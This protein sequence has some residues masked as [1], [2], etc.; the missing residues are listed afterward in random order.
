MVKSEKDL[1]VGCLSRVPTGQDCCQRYKQGIISRADKWELA[2]EIW[3][4]NTAGVRVCPMQ[5]VKR[6]PMDRIYQKIN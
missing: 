6:L 5:S 3:K 1:R 4:E 2:A